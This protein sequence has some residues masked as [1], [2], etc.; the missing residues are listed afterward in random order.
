MRRAEVDKR[1][2]NVAPLQPKVPD[3]DA[4]REAALALIERT[5]PQ[6]RAAIL[7]KDI[8]DFSLEEVADMLTTSVGADSHTAFPIAG[9]RR[10]DVGPH[11]R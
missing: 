6:T 8:F 11:R 9:V 1:Q 2:S 3:V 4:T 7:L 10:A 5:S